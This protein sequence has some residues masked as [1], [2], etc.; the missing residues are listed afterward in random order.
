M[1]GLLKDI[2]T[3]GAYVLTTELPAVGEL[4]SFELR[5]QGMGE[6]HPEM[7]LTFMARVVRRGED[8][9]GFSF[10]LPEGLEPAVWEPLITSVSILT[11][12][13]HLLLSF[14]MLRAILFVCGLSGSAAQEPVAVLASELDQARSETA[15]EIALM[16]EKRLGIGGDAQGKRARPELVA[17]ILR[18]GSW[19]L[20]ESQRELWAGLLAAS[21]DEEGADDSNNAYVDRLIHVTP[22]QARIL[23][24]GCRKAIE[25]MQ[26]SS[27]APLPAIFATPEQMIEITGIYDLT[28]IATDMAYLFDNGLVEK[29]FDFTS[30]LPTENFCISP[31]ALGLELFR[32]CRAQ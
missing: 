21:C 13:A 20:D 29:L 23:V 1:D 2:S 6:V 28:R 26:E 12:P 25:R 32:R 22:T 31:T 18:E 30:Y 7:N 9:F 16:A 3:T 11:Q 27:Q 8:G 10:V 17:R 19:S 15:V 4:I 24:A 5:G 14:R